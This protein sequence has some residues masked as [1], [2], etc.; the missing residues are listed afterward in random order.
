MNEDNPARNE[1]EALLLDFHAESIAPE[2]FARRLLDAQI[3]MPVKDEKQ[4]IAGFQS[5]TQAEPLLVEDATGHRILVVF[6]APDRAKSFLAAHPGYGGGLL[7]EFSWIL[8]RMGAGVAI[9]INPDQ[10]PGFDLD[11]EMVAMVAALLPE[12]LP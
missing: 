1:L 4:G 5:A 7:T 9:S 11:P 2:E 6:S 12:E 8:C 3:F 10:T